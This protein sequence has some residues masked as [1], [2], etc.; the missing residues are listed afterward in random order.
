M[1]AIRP[2]LACFLIAAAAV[3]TMAGSNDAA[4]QSFQVVVPPHVKCQCSDGVIEI[5]SN[6]GLAVATETS[7]T[8]SDSDSTVAVKQRL[9]IVPA[10]PFAN[11]VLTN[12]GSDHDGFRVVTIT[13]LP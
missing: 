11:L 10:T 4:L 7:A 3:R 13:A 6:V 12:R 5:R 2:L 1:R 8:V 9:Q